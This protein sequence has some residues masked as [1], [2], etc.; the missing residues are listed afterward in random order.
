MPERRTRRRR[1]GLGV[2]GTAFEEAGVGQCAGL[3][4][5][6]DDLA[7]EVVFEGGDGVFSSAGL[8]A[9]VDEGE[10]AVRV[11]VEAGRAGQTLGAPSAG[12]QFRAGMAG[13]KRVEWRRGIAPPRSPRTVRESLDSYG[14]YCLTVDPQDQCANRFGR[15]ARSRFSQSRARWGCLLNRLYLRCAQRISEPSRLRSAEYSTDLLNLP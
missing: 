7:F 14:S 1:G 4:G 2:G 3:V 9:A 6:A 10:V 15:W 11:V 12:G 5:A 13:G 8:A